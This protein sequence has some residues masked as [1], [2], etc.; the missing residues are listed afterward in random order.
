MRGPCPPLPQENFFLIFFCL[1]MVHFGAFL[2]LCFNLSIR[3]VKQSRKAVLCANCQLDGLQR[4]MDSGRIATTNGRRI[5]LSSIVL[6]TIF[7]VELA[8]AP[9]AIN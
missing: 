8:H 4:A 7:G 3:R 2:A 6:Y 1:A 5:V 9:L